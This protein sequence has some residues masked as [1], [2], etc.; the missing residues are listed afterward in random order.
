MLTSFP[1]TETTL[2]CGEFPTDGRPRFESRSITSRLLVVESLQ[3]VI[4]LVT[5]LVDRNHIRKRKSNTGQFAGEELG[6][7]LGACGDGTIVFRLSP[8]ALLLSVLGE[9]DER[10]GVCGLNGEHQI[11]ENE[12]IWVPSQ[13]DRRDVDDD[14][15]DDDGRLHDEEASRPEVASDGF[16][17]ATECFGVVVDAEWLG[18]PWTSEVL[19]LPH[20]NTAVL[21]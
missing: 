1:W 17:E 9:Q 2:L 19:T 15:H 4:E 16:R 21:G 7:R 13:R 10:R 12:R 6:I 11:Q 20:D 14:P 8:V 3:H 5:Q 18:A